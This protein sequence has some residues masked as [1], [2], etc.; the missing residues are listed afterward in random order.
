MGW[1]VIYKSSGS[2]KEVVWEDETIVV[3]PTVVKP[4]KEKKVT[5]G[6]DK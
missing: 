1:K 4:K 3:K 6:T 2:V 5:D